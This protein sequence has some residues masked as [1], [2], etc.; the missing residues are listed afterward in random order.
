MNDGT[1]CDEFRRYH[2]PFLDH[3][4]AI[5]AAGEARG[6]VSDAGVVTPDDRRGRPEASAD[7]TQDQAR[8]ESANE[9]AS[10]PNRVM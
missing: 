9:S 10:R 7:R 5:D 4:K 1:T 2:I 3:K 8:H 6:P